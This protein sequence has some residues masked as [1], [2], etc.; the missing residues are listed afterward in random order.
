VPQSREQPRWYWHVAEP[1]WDNPEFI[2]AEFHN[3]QSVTV[4]VDTEA[5]RENIKALY[6]SLTTTSAQIDVSAQQPT[7]LH[8][9][10]MDMTF[11]LCK[12]W[13]NTLRIRINS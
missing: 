1:L 5:D 9:L 2:Q 10:G 8:L 6:A 7:L 12:R 11:S 4:V 3:G 13:L